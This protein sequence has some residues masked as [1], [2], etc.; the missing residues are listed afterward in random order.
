MTRFLTL[1]GPDGR[2]LVRGET[3]SIDDPPRRWRAGR[4]GERTA[5]RIER[6]TLV[7]SEP[8]AR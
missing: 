3:P 8:E 6:P 2:G 7:T 5:H 4:A 1:L